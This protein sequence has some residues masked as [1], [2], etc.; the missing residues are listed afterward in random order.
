MVTDVELVVKSTN[1]WLVLADPTLKGVAVCK[2]LDKP[3]RIL[4]RLAQTN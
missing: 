3:W 1:D 4:Y 2:M